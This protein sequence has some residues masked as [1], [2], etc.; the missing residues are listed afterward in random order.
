VAVVLLVKML[1]PDIVS[2]E[3]ALVVSL[4]LSENKLDVAVLASFVQ[5]WKNVWRKPLELDNELNQQVAAMVVISKIV[6]AQLLMSTPR[7]LIRLIW[8]TSPKITKLTILGKHFC[9]FCR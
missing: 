4:M 5:I 1:S 3:C 2:V 6:P 8:S 7:R 9:S